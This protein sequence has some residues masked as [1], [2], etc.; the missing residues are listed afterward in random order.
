[1]TTFVP[2]SRAQSVLLPPDL[3]DWLPEDDVAHVI[4]AAVERVPLG[5]FE[6]RAA[7]G[8]R[9]QYPPRRLLL[10]LLI[11]AHANGIFSSRRIGSAANN[12]EDCGIPRLSAGAST[13]DCKA[14][15]KDRAKPCKIAPL[16]KPLRRRDSVG[17]SPRS[18]PPMSPLPAR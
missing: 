8:G 13:R 11:Y 4:V 17:A 5:A 2:F 16:L 6:V 7:P 9:A 1:M 15:P 12:A 14:P 3:R 18:S 10:A